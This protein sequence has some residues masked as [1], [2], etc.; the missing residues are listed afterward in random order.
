MRSRG[1]IYARRAAVFAFVVAGAQATATVTQVDG[2][3]V[4]VINDTNECD[5]AGSDDLQTCFNLL[6]GVAP[7][8]ATAIDAV[9]DAAQFPEVFVPNLTINV[10]FRDIAE[11]AGFENSFGWYNVGDDVL[12]PAGRAVNLHPIL[13]CGVPMMASGN[14]T[15]HTGNPAFYVVN[16][17]SSNASTASVNFASEQAAGR[18]KGG[19]IA[20]YLITPEGNPS[21]DNCGDFKNGSDGNSLFGRIYFTQRDLNND[22]DFVHHLVYSSKVVANRFYFGFEDLFRG[23]DN[24]FEDMAIQTVGLAPPCVPQAEVCDGQDNDCDGLVDAADPDLT[25]DEV[26]CLCDGVGITCQGRARVTAG[27]ARRSA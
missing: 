3:I 12:T 20:F 27:R 9:V 6:E 10:T 18:Y 24:D 21:S 13:G 19:F 26:A 17:E 7:P 22:G 14:A 23:G 5:G 11:G 15:T 2:T 16:A 8:M 25:G 4:P 1:S